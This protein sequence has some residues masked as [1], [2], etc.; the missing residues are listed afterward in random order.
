MRIL[1]P[2]E[3]LIY[4]PC[5]RGDE[6]AI[7]DAFRHGEPTDPTYLSIL[8]G[9][10]AQLV[11]DSE[12]DYAKWSS[13]ARAVIAVQRGRRIGVVKV[14]LSEAGP[15]RLA[16]I[17]AGVVADHCH[18]AKVIDLVGDVARWLY[19]LGVVEATVNYAVRPVMLDDE[20]LPGRNVE[21][22]LAPVAEFPLG[23]PRGLRFAG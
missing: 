14:M 10:S 13:G 22:L 21:Y 18:P 16:T 17:E 5:E 11:A 8:T 19:N 20:E 12:A 6:K 4:R 7:Y 2:E 9:L 15:R 1:V 3:S 23:L